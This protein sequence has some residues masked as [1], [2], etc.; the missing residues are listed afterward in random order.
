MAA[1]DDERRRAFEARFLELKQRM[2]QGLLTRAHTLRDAVQ[3]LLAGDESARKVL[4][5]EGHKLRGIAGS[6]GYSQL[7]ELAAELEQ[8]ASL[9]PPPLLGQLATKLADAAEEVGKRSASAQPPSPQPTAG[10]SSV[11]AVGTPRV[12]A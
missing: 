9:S 11:G 12:S 4:K 6:Y 10:P 8:R 3:R 7:T 2:E 5:V 1:E